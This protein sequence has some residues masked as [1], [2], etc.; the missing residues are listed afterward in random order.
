MLLMDTTTGKVF[1][2]QHGNRI[3]N[4]LHASVGRRCMRTVRTDA[5][6]QQL[7]MWRAR[8]ARKRIIAPKAEYMRYLSPHTQL[9]LCHSLKQ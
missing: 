8:K 9:G 3:A 5:D 2:K 1:V 6:L 7:W 4:V